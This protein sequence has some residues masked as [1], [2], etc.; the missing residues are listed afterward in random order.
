MRHAPGERIGDRYEIVALISTGGM[1]AIYQARDLHFTSRVVALKQMLDEVPARS[2]SKIEEHFQQEAELLSRLKHPHIPAVLDHFLIN[3]IPYI[4]MEYVEGESLLH[5]IEDCVQAT[6]RGLPIERV[7]SWA[8]QICDVLTYLHD[9][10]PPILHRDVKPAN[11]IRRRGCDEVVLVDFGLAFEHEARLGTRTMVGTL[12]YAPLEQ[13]QGKPDRSCD[14]YGLGATMY[15]LLTGRCPNPFDI[16]PLIREL[17]ELDPLLSEMVAKACAP[18]EVRYQDA[19]A[20]LRDLRQVQQ[21]MAHPELRPKAR[22]PRLLAP[23]VPAPPKRSSAA[24]WVAMVLAVPIVVG[25]MILS[26]RAPDAASVTS[27]D[28]SPSKVVAAPVA[29]TPPPLPPAPVVVPTA[30]RTQ[31]IVEIP[32]LAPPVPTPEAEKTVIVLAP[33]RPPPPVGGLAP[34]HPTLRATPTPAQ[35]AAAPPVLSV[36]ADAVLFG[37]RLAQLWGT[38]EESRHWRAFSPVET[39]GGTGWFMQNV[40]GLPWMRQFALHLDG[41]PASTAL[42]ISVG[43]VAV[44]LSRADEHPVE[45]FH[46]GPQGL[47][48]SLWQSPPET[49]DTSCDLRLVFPSERDVNF[50]DPVSNRMV[51]RHVAFPLDGDRVFL[52]QFGAPDPGLH[53]SGLVTR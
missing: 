39:M 10:E 9:R 27:P 14:L 53:L 37:G 21:E 40:K 29:L 8:Q 52:L 36:P 46:A 4:A 30:T 11:I 25:G 17:P 24:P 5:V 18:W 44:R 13:V 48:E 22:G 38:S 34:P 19:A 6:D 49:L 3:G 20:M 42:L 50:Y 2:R 15:H 35:P 47:E 31:V 12:G 32:T 16:P 43:N 1:G 45:L 33:H 28:P 41:I 7:L 51:Q 23:P 26:M